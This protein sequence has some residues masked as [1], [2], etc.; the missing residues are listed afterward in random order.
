[1]CPP[2]APSSPP[3]QSP[4]SCPP[5]TRT[6][7]T[8]PAPPAPPGP[9]APCR[10]PCPPC[11]ETP[12]CRAPPPGAPTECARASAASARPPHSPPAPPHPPLR[13]DLRQGRGHRR[14]AVVH[15]PD[16]PD[17]HMRLAPL[18]FRLRHNVPRARRLHPTRRRSTISPGSV[19][20]GSWFVRR[21]S[22]TE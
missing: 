6:S 18:V 14:L 1:M 20:T 5:E 2:P 19:V 11:S 8:A 10:P 7:P 22:K 15:M 12:R 4:E 9:T 13:T 21:I 17:V 16:R 3:P